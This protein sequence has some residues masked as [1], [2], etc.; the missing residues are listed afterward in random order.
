[1]R[2]PVSRCGGALC[3]LRAMVAFLQI[4]SGKSFQASGFKRV[5]G[6]KDMPGSLRKIDAA[7]RLYNPHSPAIGALVGA[8]SGLFDGLVFSFWQIAAI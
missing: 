1:M 8:N 7:A 5:V 4:V 6:G 3:G 2:G